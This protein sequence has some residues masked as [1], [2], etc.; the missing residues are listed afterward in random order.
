MNDI[1]PQVAA[2]HSLKLIR[3][4]G[5]TSPALRGKRS[6]IKNMGTE[7]RKRTKHILVRVS[8]EEKKL[9]EEGAAR[10]DLSVPAW[11]RKLG[12]GHRPASHVDIQAVEK[13]ARL[14]GDLG[15]VG[16]L[17]KMWLSDRN[18][19]Q[20]RQLDVPDL[21]I[22]LHALQADMKAKVKEL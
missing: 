20:A 21:L 8:P 7:T 17:L 3:P 13:I 5:S 12:L 1:P 18:A 6:R 22:Q 16:G 19:E 11:L 15:R 10:C 2:N 4:S 14:H 9:L